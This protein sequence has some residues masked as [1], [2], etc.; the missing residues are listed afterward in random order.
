MNKAETLI[1]E[2]NELLDLDT[3]SIMQFKELQ[4]IDNNKTAKME[5]G[6]KVTKIAETQRVIRFLAEFEPGTE[7]KTHWHDCTEICTILGGVMGDKATGFVYSKDERVIFSKG[8]K[9]HPFN[10]SSNTTL[11]VLVEFFK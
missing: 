6:A 8:Q 11:Y 3:S 2:I 10:P 7:I 5:G 4:S 1:N 9:H